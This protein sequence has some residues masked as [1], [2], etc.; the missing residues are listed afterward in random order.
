MFKEINNV[1]LLD[2]I[3]QICANKLTDA[4]IEVKIENKLTKEQLIQEIEV[5]MQSYA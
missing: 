4:G 2:G 3:D 5:K 1:L